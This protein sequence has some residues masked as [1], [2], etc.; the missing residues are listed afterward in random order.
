MDRRIPGSVYEKGTTSYF[1]S[2]SYYGQYTHFD[3]DD[4]KVD[5][6]PSGVPAGVT[7]L[8][9]LKSDSPTPLDTPSEP[10]PSVPSNP[11]PP[12]DDKYAQL[13]LRC[14]VINTR[15][16]TKDIAE[17]KQYILSSETPGWLRLVLGEWLYRKIYVFYHPKKKEEVEPLC[18]SLI[19][20]IV[21]TTNIVLKGLYLHYH[22]VIA[23]RFLAQHFFLSRH[24]DEYFVL[25]MLNDVQLIQTT[26]YDE[27]LEHFLR[28]IKRTDNFEQQSNLLDV[29]LRHFRKNEEVERIYQKMRFGDTKGF[30][31]L[32]T[33]AQNAHDETVLPGVMKA[34]VKLR[35]WYKN[36]PYDFEPKQG[37][38]FV[39]KDVLEEAL[40]EL[41]DL[42]QRE[43]TSSVV[44]RAKIDVTVYEE[45]ITIMNLFIAL[46]RYIG[47]SSS[48]E[49][50]L[51]RFEE[52]MKEADGLCSSAYIVRFVNVLQGIDPEFAVT[53]PFANQLQGALTHYLNKHLQNASD[54][55]I[56]GSYSEE[57][58]EEYLQFIERYTNE[59]LPELYQRYGRKDVDDNILGVLQ[60]L[61]DWKKW[62][63]DNQKVDCDY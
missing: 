59:F 44:V 61:T 13:L 37:E 23:L 20:P 47:M 43:V 46:C 21:E 56:A 62:K 57:S 55:V 29:L 31:N 32:Y 40:K 6:D 38:I 14:G 41:G 45:G 17:V 11:S 52:E 1:T 8:S 58:K 60:K 42:G 54:L 35:K 16:F 12:N 7:L 9:E 34:A 63:L 26:P 49:L 2:N 36:N 15:T 27:I 50:L 24:P 18:A 30:V 39:E 4:E 51:Q 25:Q 28:W 48:K 19:D 10:V 33:D 3:D 5:D 53:H 22:N